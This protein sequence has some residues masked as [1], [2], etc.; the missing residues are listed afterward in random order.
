MGAT[1]QK[2]QH[3]AS[4]ASIGWLSQNISLTNNSRVSPKNDE[5]IVSTISSLMAIPDGLGL[6]Y[7]KTLNICS[8]GFVRQT[9]FI[10]IGGFD[11]KRQSGLSEQFTATRR[12]R[13]KNKH[14]D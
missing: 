12:S 1:T 6:F 3:A 7:G 8:R 14:A 9:I 5:R 10:E 13:R 11:S 2:L 4:I